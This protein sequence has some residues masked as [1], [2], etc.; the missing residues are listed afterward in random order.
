[1][2]LKCLS[3]IL[4]GSFSQSIVNGG[5]TYNA[6]PLFFAGT[7]DDLSPSVSNRQPF[8]V[9]IILDTSECHSIPSSD[10]ME[11]TFKTV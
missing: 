7:S 4:S 5:E 9:K 11:R 3:T 6:C 2:T 1:M 8:V 10:D